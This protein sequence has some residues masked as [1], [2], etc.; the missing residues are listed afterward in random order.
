MRLVVDSSRSL[1]RELISLIFE[2]CLMRDT[3]VLCLP[4]NRVKGQARNDCLVETSRTWLVLFGPDAASRLIASRV[5]RHFL[6]SEMK[7]LSTRRRSCYLSGWQS[8]ARARGVNCL[9]SV[10]WCDAFPWVEPG[11]L[12]SWSSRC[13]QQI[14][15]P[16]LALI[17]ALLHVLTQ[18]ILILIVALSVPVVVVAS[19]CVCLCIHVCA[20]SFPLFRWFCCLAAP[21]QWRV[22]RHARA[23]V[24]ASFFLLSFLFWRCVAYPSLSLKCFLSLVSRACFI[25]SL[26]TE[27][28]S[29]CIIWCLNDSRRAEISRDRCRTMIIG[30]ICLD[31]TFLSFSLSFLC[32]TRIRSHLIVDE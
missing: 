18:S 3:C 2:S 31:V 16:S 22:G 9:S 4:V 23:H 32:S 24:L 29:M 19:R 1:R 11:A 17:Y 28:H 6:F 14:V 27:I 13:W 25:S 21:A 7:A 5:R 20:R 10:K 8:D 12:P 26:K 30:W 15:R